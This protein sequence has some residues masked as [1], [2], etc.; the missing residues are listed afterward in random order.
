MAILLVTDH[1]TIHP[2]ICRMGTTS[3]VWLRAFAHTPAKRSQADS[4]AGCNVNKWVYLY[5]AGPRRPRPIAGTASLR[6]GLELDKPGAGPATGYRLQC[7]CNWNLHTCLRT[8]RCRTAVH[9]LK[10]AKIII[11]YFRSY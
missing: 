5:A 2:V 6:A 10:S 3:R 4:G 1:S 8:C 9:K 11:L 7:N